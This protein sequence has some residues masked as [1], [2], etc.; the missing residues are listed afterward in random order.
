MI[1]KRVEKIGKTE[2]DFEGMEIC[3]AGVSVRA[4]SQLFRILRFLIDNPYRVFSREELIS[5]VWPAKTRFK[6][7]KNYRT[8]DNYIVFV[9]RLLEDDPSHP[10][11]IRT[12][13]SAGYRFVPCPH[14]PRGS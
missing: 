14:K 1:R 12:I 6:Q 11:Y 13:Y 2:I 10:I 7:R 4:T 8:V 3:R 9:R 5:A